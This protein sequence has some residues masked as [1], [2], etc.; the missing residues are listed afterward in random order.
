MN[1][2]TA[3]LQHEAAAPLIKLLSGQPVRRCVITGQ[4]LPKGALLRMAAQ[5]GR[6]VPD[7]R[8]VMPGRGVWLLPELPVLARA[9]CSD[10]LRLGG[11]NNQRLKLAADLPEKVWQ[12]LKNETATQLA[13]LVRQGVLADDIA[14]NDV[15]IG[16][17]GDGIIPVAG[18]NELLAAAG[19][20][21]LVPLATKMAIMPALFWSGLVR[22]A[23]MYGSG[24][25]KFFVYLRP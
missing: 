22:Y 21:N 7:F 25:G 10:G 5:D 4:R 23:L 19:Q 16:D 20:D 13:G 6:L 15:T 9:V 8:A 17:G 1:Q 3:K 24:A 2:K 18:Y 12:Y 14:G 11:R